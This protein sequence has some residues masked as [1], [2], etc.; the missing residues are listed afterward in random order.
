L[1]DPA[2]VTAPKFPAMRLHRFIAEAF[3]AV[4]L[5]G[6]DA[7]SVAELMIL[8]DLRGADGHGIFRLPQYV[9]RIRAGG[10]NP[11]PKMHVTSTGPATAV[12]DG[13]NGMGHL[14]MRRAAELAIEKGKEFGIGW[15][16]TRASNHAGPAA[17][18]AMMPAAQGMIGVYFAVANANHMAP[19]GGS[20]LLL[21]TN[22]I[23]AAIP[24]GTEPSIVLDMATTV[25][26][27]GTIKLAAMSGQR[28]PEGWMID[29]ME[30]RPLTDPQRS[31]EGLLLPIGGHKGYGLALIFGLLAGTLNQA[32]FGRAVIDF[33]ADD[34]TPTNTGQTIVAIDLTRF[35]PVEEF[36]RS[37]DAVIRDF[38][39]S[40]KL[41]GVREIRLPGE[42]GHKRWIERSRDG[43]P[44]RQPV[45]MKLRNLAEELGIEPI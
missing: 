27:Y 30:G 37:V 40:R 32:A 19:W 12:L 31:G 11:H 8:A 24:A 35:Q 6:A 22:P 1:S 41:A 10:I 26:S 3:V 25:V 38:R 13:D 18:Y 28:M 36:K 21:G 43:I 33:N 20:E 2:V 23:A 9:K 16:G 7:D 15:V 42:Q 4:G 44:L 29:A 45:L 5:P 17:L 14:V 39:T 34:Q